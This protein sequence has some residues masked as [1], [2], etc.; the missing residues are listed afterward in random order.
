[1]GALDGKVAIVTGAGRGVGRAHALEL[2]SEGASVV[3]N[4]VGG[5]DGV[6]EEITAAG[7][8]AVANTSSVSDWA[9][10][11]AM[12]RQAIDTFG[13]LHVLVNNAGIL[14]DGMS[15]NLGEAEW[16]VVLDVHLKGHFCLSRH[17][18]AYWRDQAKA[19]AT[20]G[21]RIINTSSEAGLYGSAGQAN[22]ASAKAGIIGLTWVFAREYERYGVTANAIAPRAR[23]QMTENIPL[24][25]AK[26][27][28]EFDPFEP[29][30]V[31][32]VVAWLATD[33]SADISGQIFIVMGGGVHLIAPFELAASLIKKDAGFSLAELEAGKTQLFT[34]RS[35]GVPKMHGPAWS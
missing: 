26:A 31:A 23:T 3:V 35:P 1:M 30:H 27:E 29:V 20:V 24:F 17:A 6:V 8:N 2:A 28:G 13:D 14:R 19:G 34:G 18:G 12:V 33:A 7:G 25:A 22:Y 4:D 21:R 32:R 15:F 16:D 11:A 5:A 10:T 9:A